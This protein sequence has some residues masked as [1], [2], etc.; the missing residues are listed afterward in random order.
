MRGRRGAA[1]A[2]HRD[3]SADEQHGT[4]ERPESTKLE[5]AR[6]HDQEDRA[7]LL[8]HALTGM[9]QHYATATIA[10]LVE[11]ANKVRGTRDLTPLLR[12]VNG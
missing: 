2:P 4:P 6:V 12:A 5:R 7:S 11:A 10:R 9:P 1:V 8:G 3:R